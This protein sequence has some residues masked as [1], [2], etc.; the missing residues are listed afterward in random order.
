[1]QNK[2]ESYPRLINFPTGERRLRHKNKEVKCALCNEPIGVD[3]RCGRFAYTP[4]WAKGTLEK[5]ICLS[6]CRLLEIGD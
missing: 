3:H 6:C 5:F 2:F 4:D 1:M